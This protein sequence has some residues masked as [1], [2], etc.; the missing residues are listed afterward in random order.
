MA[1][2]KYSFLKSSNVQHLAS[3]Y[4]HSVRSN[5]VKGFRTASQDVMLEHA[6][7]LLAG[8]AVERELKLEDSVVDILEMHL[9]P[10]LCC[11]VS[12]RIIQLAQIVS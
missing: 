10:N 11:H 3:K 5:D 12:I 7:E 4:S 2:T 9:P 8:L 6:A 1:D